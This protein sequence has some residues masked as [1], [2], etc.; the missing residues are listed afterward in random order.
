MMRSYKKDYPRPQLVRQE[1]E[2][3]NGTWDFLFDDRNVGEK[4][5]FILSFPENLRLRFHL[6][7]K[8]S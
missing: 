5:S 4:E 2:N 3:L 1:W 6:P 7:M 8:R